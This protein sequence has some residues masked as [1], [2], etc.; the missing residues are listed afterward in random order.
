MAPS[1]MNIEPG[2]A[3]QCSSTPARKSSGSVANQRGVLVDGHARGVRGELLLGEP[4]L[5]VAAGVDEGADQQVAVLDSSSPGT[6]P[7]V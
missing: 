4:V 1:W 6:S 3:P 5:V 2:A 7:M